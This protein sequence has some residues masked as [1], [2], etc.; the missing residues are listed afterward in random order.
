MFRTDTVLAAEITR[1]ARHVRWIDGSWVLAYYPVARTNPFQSLLYS[2]ATAFGVIPVGMVR[3]DDLA[4]LPC[5]IGMG[6]GAVL[7]LHWLAGITRDAGTAVEATDKVDEFIGRLRAIQQQGVRVL[8]TVHNRLPHG[9]RYHAV[10]VDFRS[11]LAELADVVHVMEATTAADVADLYELPEGRTFVVPHPSYV[12][13]YPAS[14]DRDA[15]RFTM[16]FGPDDVVVGMIGSIQPYKGVDELIEAVSDPALASGRLRIVV[17]GMPGRDDD[18]VALA[19]RLRRCHL[20]TSV[21]RR[22]DDRDLASIASALDAM[23]LPY[24]ASLNSGAAMLAL[25]FG[26]PVIA[27]R[28]GAFRSLAERGFCLAYD[29]GDPGGLADALREA[30]A[31]VTQVDRRAIAEY[32]ATLAGPAVSDRF[33]TELGAMLGAIDPVRPDGSPPGSAARARDSGARTDSAIPRPRRAEPVSRT[34]RSG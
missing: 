24:R 19:Q 20:V 15:A 18:S 25:S 23:V 14:R 28:I 5:A 29:P 32:A 17:A 7:H 6:T 13:V 21:P 31:W 3:A 34:G 30:P 27:P 4:A 9:Y 10:E 8:W 2:R 16:G 33:F 11:R 22:I 26:L 1:A 12:D